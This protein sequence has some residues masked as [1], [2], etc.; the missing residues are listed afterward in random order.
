VVFFKELLI[1]TPLRPITHRSPQGVAA[2]EIG[3]LDGF[4]RVNSTHLRRTLL[5]FW[6]ATNA[7]NSLTVMA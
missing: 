1:S 3:K 5:R 4:Q 2:A 7:P 6:W